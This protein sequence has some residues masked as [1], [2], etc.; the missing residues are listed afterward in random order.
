MS[1]R[2]G[3]A[4][5][6]FI[7]LTGC[8]G[9]PSRSSDAGVPDAHVAED[10]GRADAGLRD[11]GVVDP[12]TRITLGDDFGAL[13]GGVTTNH[14]SLTLQ[15]DAPPIEVTSVTVAGIA[16]HLGEAVAV[17]GRMRNSGI[18]TLCLEPLD[19]LEAY[20]DNRRIGGAAGF[21]PPYWDGESTR[22]VRCLAPGEDG[23]FLV[24]DDESPADAAFDMEVFS[25]AFVASPGGLIAPHPDRPTPLGV[26]V[27]Q[28]EDATDVELR[29]ALGANSV[30]RIDA[31]VFATARDG[32]VVTHVRTFGSFLAP[33]SEPVLEA[34][35]P[36]V[37][38]GAFAFLEIEQPAPTTMSRRLRGTPPSPGRDELSLRIRRLFG[39]N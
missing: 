9:S 36:Y 2:E 26:N 31:V 32:L 6:L 35:F 5:L 22:S 23:A 39:E 17:S 16:T 30:R 19:S 37:A 38:E 28:A 25:Y 11:A 8:V 12:F 20:F 14:L 29:Y 33:F 1:R 27:V 7:V 10:A 13:E 24:L 3:A 15:N 18:E 34:Q 21:A 4:A